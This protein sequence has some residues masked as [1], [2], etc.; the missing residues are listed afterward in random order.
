MSRALGELLVEGRQLV[1]R[2]HRSPRLERRGEALVARPEPLTQLRNPGRVETALRRLE[3]LERIE[4]RGAKAA[5]GA[6]IVVGEGHGARKVS[7]SG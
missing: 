6:G 7:S 2:L 5:Q 4:G 3:G 1:R